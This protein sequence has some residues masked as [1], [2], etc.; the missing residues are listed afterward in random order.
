MAWSWRLV[1]HCIHLF[2]FASIISMVTC[3][4]L[5]LYNTTVSPPSPMLWFISVHYILLAIMV[6]PLLTRNTLL[7]ISQFPSLMLSVKVRASCSILCLVLVAGMTAEAALDEPPPTSVAAFAIPCFFN[8]V[9]RIA[10]VHVAPCF[11]CDKDSI[12]PMIQKILDFLTIKCTTFIDIFTSIC[13][14]AQVARLP[15]TSYAT[16]SVTDSFGNIVSAVL[17]FCMVICSMRV[18]VAKHTYKG[19]DLV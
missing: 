13:I 17:T 9:V 11:V 1:I 12:D 18:P 8:L 10:L 16:K 7:Q 14:I 15:D 6:L 19:V 2:L 4:W 3:W 5:W